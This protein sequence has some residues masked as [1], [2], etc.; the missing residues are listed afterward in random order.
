MNGYQSRWSHWLTAVAT[1]ALCAPQLFAAQTVSLAWDPNTEPDLGGYRLYYGI[2]N[3]LVTN[4]LN[5]SASSTNVT[6][7]GLIE[8]Q[9]YFFFLTATNTS[10]LESDPSN[11]VIYTVPY[12]ALAAWRALYFSTTDLA[13]PTKEATLWGDLADPDKDGRNNLMEYALGLNPVDQSDARQGITVELKSDGSY[14]YQYLTY[15]R[16]KT[17]ATLLYLPEVSGDKKNWYSGSSYTQDIG[18]TSLNADFD[19]AQCKNL[20][21]VTPGDRQFIRLK[22]QR[23]TN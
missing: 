5:I 22:I 3:Q 19:A 16:R 13:D 14:R 12:S 23:L 1:F 7:P 20:T 4:T 9:T 2:T 18:M 15:N 11:Q 21:P 17:D 6:V 8:G 10:G